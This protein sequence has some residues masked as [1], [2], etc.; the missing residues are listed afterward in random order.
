MRSRETCLARLRAVAGSLLIVAIMLAPGLNRS[1]SANQP[2]FNIESYAKDIVAH[3]A[4]ICP[5]APAG[6]MAAWDTCRKGMGTGPEASWRGD[7]VLWGG[8]QPTKVNLKDKRTTIFRGDLFQ[9]LYMSLLMFTGKYSIDKSP[10][11]M[12]VIRMQSFFRNGLPPGYYP[13]PFWHASEKWEAYEKMNEFSLRMDKSGKMIFAARAATGSEE[14]RGT[15]A[16]VARPPFLGDFMW[17]ND[18]GVA[19]PV[20]TLFSGLYSDDNPN[21]A[22][23]DEAY[24]KFAIGLRDAD[25]TVCHQPAGHSRMNKLTLLNTPL[26]TATL[27]G[28]VLEDV[29]SGRMPVDDRGDKKALSADLK[30]KLLT[31]GEAL[32]ALMKAADRWEKDN[33]RVKFIPV[34]K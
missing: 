19:Q 22:A 7:S 31:D 23:M 11:G 14:G 34:A 8:E 4:K 3:F 33:N 25:C 24:R 9:D 30:K 1:A 16:S 13:Y 2:P 20:V 29:R 21:M 27:I 5:V 6:D 26:H 17:R 15:Y 10:D 18:A 28:P 32:A 12:H